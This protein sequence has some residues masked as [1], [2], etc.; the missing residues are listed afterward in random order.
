M[1]LLTLENHGFVAIIDTYGSHLNSL[2]YN[3]R[4]L[5][6]P[7][8]DIS[9][10]HGSV[11]A[12]WPNRIADG[13]YQF[14]GR[15]YAVEVNEARRH[16]ALHGLVTNLEWAVAEIQSDSLVLTLTLPASNGYPW[17]LDLTSR[18]QIEKEGIS[19]RIEAINVGNEVAPYGISIHPYLL[20]GTETSVNN[21]YLEFASEEFLEVDEDR[22]LPIEVRDVSVRDFDF[23]NSTKIGERFLDHA[24]KIPTNLKSNRVN[25]T[26]AN[27]VGTFMEFD[28]KARWIQI[29]TADRDGGRDSRRCLVVEPMSCPPDAFNSGIDLIELDP[30]QSFSMSWLI[31][32]IK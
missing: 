17:S 27:G 19:W 25:L 6:E 16:N 7:K 15:L 20:T 2:T 18:F 9:R 12:P 29:H 31:G 32:P 28:D 4:N 24:F 5:I 14:R 30:G 11:L 10:F 1:P 13:M 8:P 26:D 21:F 23:N 22:L 3:G